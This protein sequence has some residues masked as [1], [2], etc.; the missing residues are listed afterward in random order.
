MHILKPAFLEGGASVVGEAALRAE[1]DDA[2]DPP[3]LALRR[4]HH[5]ELVHVVHHHVAPVAEPVEEEFFKG[6]D[7][8]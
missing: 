2:R 4:L 8:G 3:R 1:A 6:P 7:S 5:A